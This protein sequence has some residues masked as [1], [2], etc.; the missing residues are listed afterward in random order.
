MGGGNGNPGDG[1]KGPV[2]PEAD[3]VKPS[4]PWLVPAGAEAYALRTANKRGW[5]DRSSNPELCRWKKVQ[6]AA[7]LAS[8]SRWSLQAKKIIMTESEN[9]KGVARRRVAQFKIGD[10]DINES[11]AICYQCAL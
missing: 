4:R 1:Q 6:R 7:A 2:V 9:V 10:F 3:K 11:A 8:F 5:E